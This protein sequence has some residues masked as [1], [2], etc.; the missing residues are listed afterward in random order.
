MTLI[1]E[2]VE[3][4][5]ACFLSRGILS[6]GETGRGALVACCLHV[7]TG[8]DS[9]LILRRMPNMAKESKV[10]QKNYTLSC[11]LRMCLCKITTLSQIFLMSS[12]AT[13][14]LLQNM[15]RDFSATRFLWNTRPEKLQ[16]TMEG[17]KLTLAKPCKV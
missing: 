12:C 7:P 1:N 17:V 4:S 8:T 9:F 2:E 10:M 15:L 3:G 14:C 11:I 16:K 6:R 13:A 5:Y